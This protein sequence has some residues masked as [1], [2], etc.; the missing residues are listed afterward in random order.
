MCEKNFVSRFVQCLRGEVN[1]FWVVKFVPFIMSLSIAP[2]LHRK[3]AFTGIFC[4]S[5]HA[6]KYHKRDTLYLNKG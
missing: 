6:Q 5:F 4:D 3:H 2:L 1:N